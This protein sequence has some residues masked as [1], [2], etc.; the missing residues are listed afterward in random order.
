MCR[1]DVNRGDTVKIYIRMFGRFRQQF[2]E[3]QEIEVPGPITPVE[4]LTMVG[5]TS[6]DAHD[7]LFDG[8]SGIRKH[9]ILMVNKARI[10]HDA[11]TTLHLADGD[12]LGV[13]PPVAG[14]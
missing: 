7:T 12:E 9:I 2:G 4:A 10:S 3:W 13:L 6:P 1:N 11:C 14:G 5:A 8:D